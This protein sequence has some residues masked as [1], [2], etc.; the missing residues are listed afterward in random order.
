MVTYCRVADQELLLPTERFIIDKLKK[1]A[2]K[3]KNNKSCGFDNIP[4]EVWK[5]G[6]LNEQ[7]LLLP[8]GNRC[9]EKNLHYNIL[10]K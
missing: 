9:L 1:I 6:N 3:V 7:L 8:T 4:A 10:P 2:G 5:S